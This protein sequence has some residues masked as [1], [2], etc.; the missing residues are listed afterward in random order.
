MVR[1]VFKGVTGS[2]PKNGDLNFLAQFQHICALGIGCINFD[3]SQKLLQ[4]AYYNFFRTKGTIKIATRNV[5]WP[6]N[7]LKMRLQP[8][9]RSTP[10]SAG[11]AHSAP[12]PL[13]GLG[14]G[15]GRRRKRRGRRKGEEGRGG[16]GRTPN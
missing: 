6:Q 9:L 4:L 5:S 12:R 11:K 8:G 2:N 16:E 1:A 15:E 13:A 3:A 14:G 7:I 10:D